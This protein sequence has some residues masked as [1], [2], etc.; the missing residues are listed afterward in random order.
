MGN[1]MRRMILGALALLAVCGS[2][3]AYDCKDA[4]LPAEVV[5]CSDPQLVKLVDQRDRAL[6]AARKRAGAEQR[7]TLNAEQRGWLRE[8]PRRC[9]VAA[10]GKAPNPIGKDLIACFEHAIEARTAALRDY[11]APAAKPPAVKAA[12]PAAPPPSAA[13]AP[14]QEATGAAAAPG[15]AAI[16]A[17]KTYRLKFTFA[18]RSPGKLAQVL[19]AL[20]RN[21]FNFPLNQ[22]DC[23]PV[24]EGRAAT[25]LAL[26]GGVAKLRLCS[27]EAGCIDVYADAA[28]LETAAG[29]PSQISPSAAK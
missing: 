20:Q 28:A 8:Y 26:D 12:A 18:C 21:D 4:R 22:D 15:A 6:A 14:P 7:K 13:E 11:G 17:G 27:V 3:R 2:A 10:K 23:L 24:P 19:A 1:H 25:L 5:I 9:G 29:E 16:A